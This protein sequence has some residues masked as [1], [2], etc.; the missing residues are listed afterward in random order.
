MGRV[1]NTQKSRKSKAKMGGRG[2]KKIVVPESPIKTPWRP[3]TTLWRLRKHAATAQQ[4][5][6]TAALENL[7]LSNRVAPSLL[8]SRPPTGYKSLL[9]SRPSTAA[10][11]LSSTRPSTGHG[12]IR[13]VAGSVSSTDQEEEFSITG[14]K[15]IIILNEGDIEEG[16]EDIEEVVGSGDT[17]G[18]E[19]SLAKWPH[20]H[21]LPLRR[22]ILKK[23]KKY[24]FRRQ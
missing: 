11:Y 14:D 2:R 9:G 18:L 20:I 12:S 21:S 4:A 22:K 7:I 13:A 15:E 23:G 6:Y 17:E 16:F 24:D 5:L 1:S 8:G 10:G 3:K 19:E